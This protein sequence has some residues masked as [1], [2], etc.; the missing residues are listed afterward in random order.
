MLS[1]NTYLTR[2]TDVSEAIF[3]L[4]LFIYFC[5]MTYEINTRKGEHIEYIVMGF[6]VKQEYSVSFHKKLIN[7]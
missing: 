4:K 7:R 2:H 6:I 3:H 5:L 1:N